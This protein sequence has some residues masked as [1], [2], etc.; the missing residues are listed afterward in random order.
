MQLLG[1]QV[2]AEQG[3]KRG[4]TVEFVGD[5]GEVISVQLRATEGGD[6]NRQNALEK[7]RDLMREVCDG[8]MTN[9]VDLEA[10]PSAR[11]SRDEEEMES[12]LDEGLQDSFP[13]S[14]PVSVTSSTTVGGSDTNR[15]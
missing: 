7:A 2:H 4:F 1:T 14:D 12:Q 15:P 5:G 10:H 13:A 11:Q 9:A 8:D 6:L 3:G